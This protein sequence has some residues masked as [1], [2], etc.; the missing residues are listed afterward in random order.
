MIILM[1][2][3]ITVPLTFTIFPTVLEKETGCLGANKGKLR[4][5][6]VSPSITDDHHFEEAMAKKNDQFF[7]AFSN[8]ADARKWLLGSEKSKQK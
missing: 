1:P 6:S 5:A 4:R 7:H 8:I 3:S 2:Y